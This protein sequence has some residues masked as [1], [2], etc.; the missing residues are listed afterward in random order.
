MKKWMTILMLAAMLLAFGALAESETLSVT[1]NGTVY[2]EAD[3]VRASL[4]ISMQGADLAQLQQDANR[5][6]I[7]ICDS[8]KAVGLDEKS[9]TTNYIY[10][11]PRYDYSESVERMVGYAITNSLSIVTSDIDRIGEYI[12]A[13]FSAGAN[14]FDSIEFFISDSS[15]AQNK[16]L[17]LAVQDAMNKGETIA[18]ASGCKLAGIIEIY[19]G[20]QADYYANSRAG[21][22]YFAEAAMDSAAGTT[23]RASQINVSAAV[24]FTFA[25][26]AK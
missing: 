8:L 19:E 23:V 7:A 11:S 2:V 12:D 15:A 9:I 17:E 5:T 14:S 21:A 24:Q 6:I 3:R 16:A 10:I 20:S 1:G 13:A 25:L 26:E 18:A 22:K 4:G